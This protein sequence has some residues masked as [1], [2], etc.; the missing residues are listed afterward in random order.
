[1]RILAGLLLCCVGTA[2]VT[3]NEHP[4]CRDL[5][6][7]YEMFSPEKLRDI[8]ESCTDKKLRT[9]FYHRAYHA[10]LIEESQAYAGLETFRKN[11]IKE[12]ITSYAMYI[13][14]VEALSSSWFPDLMKR[15]AFLNNQY[16]T[17]TEIAEL[18]LHGY[19]NL[20]ERLINQTR[21]NQ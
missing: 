19:D 13:A 10:D 2:S 4:A 21:V 8:A 6:M 14:L 1:M 18:R 9:L 16:E 11:T 7:R 3:A 20:A 12:S 5:D 17:H 15:A